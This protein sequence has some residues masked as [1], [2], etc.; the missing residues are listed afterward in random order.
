MP[1]S[2]SHAAQVTTPHQHPLEPN[3]G[4]RASID[5][6]NGLILRNHLSD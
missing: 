4:V 2:I 3:N 6:A 1:S 5:A